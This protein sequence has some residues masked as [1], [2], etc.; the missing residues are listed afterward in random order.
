[1]LVKAAIQV[2][3]SKPASSGRRRSRVRLIGGSPRLCDVKSQAPPSP[4]SG[5]IAASSR[6]AV[7]DSGAVLSLSS[8]YDRKLLK[9]SLGA[10]QTSGSRSCN[11]D[12]Y[13]AFWPDM[14]A[15]LALFDSWS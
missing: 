15:L 3:K 4:I 14:R 10:D 1:M 6:H 12:A 8:G 5:E 2:S 13:D 9:Q 7:R 11:W